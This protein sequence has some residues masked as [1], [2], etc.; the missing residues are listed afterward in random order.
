MFWREEHSSAYQL[1]R[2]PA[3]KIW[4]EEER[5]WLNELSCFRTSNW[6]PERLLLDCFLRYFEV[7]RALFRE[8]LRIVAVI[9][10]RLKLIDN[11][12]LG[13]L[14]GRCSFRGE[15]WLE[16]DCTI[17]QF[18]SALRALYVDDFSLMER[19]QQAHFNLKKT[20]RKELARYLLCKLEQR[21]AGGSIDWEMV[22]R[23]KG[24]T[25]EHINPN[26]EGIGN[27]TLMRFALNNGL[28]A[29]KY[30]DK[31]EH[32]QTSQF[33]ITREIARRYARFEEAQISQRKEEIAKQ[34]CQ[35]WRIDF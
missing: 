22:T 5:N 25:L 26:W 35:I 13:D 19:F 32:Y 28:G 21:R 14:G 16:P 6:I 9:S 15:R 17:S 10:F 2:A 7:D 12:Q 20:K 24:C 27:L 33:H 11:G 1:L 18:T 23:S 31:R 4:S 29:S 30:E 8:A 34:I 3:A